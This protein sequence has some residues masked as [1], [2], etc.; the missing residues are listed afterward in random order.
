MSGFSISLPRP[1]TYLLSAF[2]SLALAASAVHAQITGT[3][4]APDATITIPGDQLPASECQ[5][6]GLDPSAHP[7][8]SEEKPP[9]QEEPNQKPCPTNPAGSIPTLE[10]VLKDNKV[11]LPSR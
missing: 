1:A 4:G 8:Y 3:P 7:V 9:H 11:D 2:A 5:D 10:K 6:A